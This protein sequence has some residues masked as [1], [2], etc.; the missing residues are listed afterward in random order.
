MNTTKLSSK[1]QVIIPKPIRTAHLWEAGQELIVIDTNEGV[2]L[3]PKKPF[4]T[5]TLSEVTSSLNYHG[6]T[7]TQEDLEQAIK[8]GALEQLK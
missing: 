5:T 6:E 8:R 7:K 3:K 4:P 2:L 1:G